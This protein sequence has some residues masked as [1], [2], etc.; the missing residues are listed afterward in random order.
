MEKAKLPGLQCCIVKDGRIVFATAYG[1]ANIKTQ[2]PMTPDSI[3]EIASISK[4]FTGTAAM[5][6]AER[7]L[8]RLDGDIGEAL[9]WPARNPA[10]PGAP[11]TTRM[12]MTHTSSIAD[13]EV[14]WNGY[15]VGDSPLPLN[16]WC[17]G[18]LTPGGKYWSTDNWAAYAPGSTWSYSGAGA[19]TCGDVVERVSH[20]PFDTWCDQNIFG[21]LGMT[22]TSWRIADL[23]K[24]LLATPYTWNDP[25]YEPYPLSGCPDYPDSMV[26]TSVNQLG[27][28]LIAYLQGGTYQGRQILAPWAVEAMLTPYVTGTDVLTGS[29]VSQGLFWHSNDTFVPGRTLWGHT[30][31][32]YGIS[33]EM[34]MDRCRS[35]GVIVL[36]NGEGWWWDYGALQTIVTKLFQK[37]DR[38]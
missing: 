26:H 5:H 21:Q 36:A 6:C 29:P 17:R 33:A 10:Y 27:K 8:L 25:Q 23:P 30:G 13:S 20:T 2:T 3:F 35:E 14:L 19:A 22:N 11:V 37:A 16:K 1:W 38:M 15:S 9:G 34:Y 7:G 28:F 31:A 4:T 12:L 32:D 18:Y 24:E